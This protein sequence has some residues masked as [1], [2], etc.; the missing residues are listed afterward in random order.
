MTAPALPMPSRVRALRRDRDGR[1]IPWFV[2]DQG[3]RGPRAPTPDKRI[4]ALR[5]GICWVCGQNLPTGTRTRRQNQ[6]VPVTF[7]VGATC[8]INRL[9]TDPPSHGSCATY[10]VEACPFMTRPDVGGMA[11]WSTHE[12]TI[13]RPRFGVGATVL[14]RMGNATAV[15]WWTE[16]RLAN[17]DEAVR[18]LSAA[19]I[20]LQDECR[21]DPDPAGANN[22]LDQQFR[23]AVRY[24]PDE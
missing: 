13:Q 2:D 12:F 5:D 15:S 24:L 7:L 9:A 10:A 23:D 18:F 8:I 3:G 1:P 17:R 20:R 6:P 19:L 11:L 16:G 21:Y 4:V 14:L 22:V